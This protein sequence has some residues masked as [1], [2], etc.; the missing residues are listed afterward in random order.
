M[1]RL[2]T[3]LA[4]STPPAGVPLQAYYKLECGHWCEVD[5]E[6]AKRGIGMYHECRTCE[7]ASNHDTSRVRRRHQRLGTRRAR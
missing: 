7:E 1:R 6:V 2:I 3:D 5:P 4:L